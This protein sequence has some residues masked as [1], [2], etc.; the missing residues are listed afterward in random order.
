MSLRAVEEGLSLGGAPIWLVLG[1]ARLLVDRAVARLVE[2][3]KARCGPPQFNLSTFHAGDGS[4]AAALTAARTLP[5]M[6]GLRV[7]VVRDVEQ[8]DDTFM[9]ALLA[10]AEEPSATTMLV[11]SGES[12]PKTRKGGTAW[13]QKVPK[14]VEKRG[15]VVK[16]SS[17]DVA[18]P[19]FAREHARALGKDLGAR[20]ASLLV[21]LVGPDLGRLAREVE[22]IALF[23]GDDAAIGADDIH[24]VCSLLAEAVVWD[25]TTGIASRDANTALAALH[26]LL[27]D[28]DASHRLL[29]LVVW[30]IRQLLMVAEGAALGRNDAEIAESAGMRPDQVARL[31]RAIDKRN[32]H[33]ARMF[34]RL[35][36]ANRTMNRSR[37]GDRKVLETLIVEL[38][39][40]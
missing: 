18:P 1:D 24:A 6:A 32:L 14:A 30:Q 34:E 36:E 25:L 19:S 9:E 16:L 12:L 40:R 28:G 39:T 23:V 17:R 5:M 20:E 2:W 38:C 3:G 31:R 33:P 35:A 37:A 13:A 10:Y 27:E 7:V 21:E 11:V 26:R 22:K 4:A 15:R 8:A 29:S